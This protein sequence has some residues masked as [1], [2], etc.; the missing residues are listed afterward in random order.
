[1]VIFHLSK[2][3]TLPNKWWSLS[4]YHNGI[5]Q[6]PNTFTKVWIKV[7]PHGFEWPPKFLE[8]LYVELILLYVIKKKD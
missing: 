5:M 1:M 6:L 7:Y 3:S 2:T 4:Y 8:D